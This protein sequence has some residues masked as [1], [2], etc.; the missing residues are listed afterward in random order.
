MIPKTWSI[1][2]RSVKQQIYIINKNITRIKAKLLNCSV[3]FKPSSN[4]VDLLFDRV[5]SM[6]FQPNEDV[7]TDQTK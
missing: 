1:K 2:S 7:K 5:A 4:S 3:Y 6:S